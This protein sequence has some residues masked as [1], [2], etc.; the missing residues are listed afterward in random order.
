M[1]PAAETMFAPVE[2]LNAW[3]DSARPGDCVVYA[4]GPALDPSAAP[5][6]LVRRWIDGGEVL[7]KQQRHPAQAGVFHYIAQRRE[8]RGEAVVKRVRRNGHFEETPEGRLFL[9][10]VRLANLGLPCPCNREL[11]VHASLRDGEAVKYRLKLLE[12]SG[13]IEVRWL[14]GGRQVTI[15]ETGATTALVELMRTSIAR[16]IGA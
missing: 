14:S 4:T 10:L 7:A 16:R 6:A 2:R 9:V 5:A 3:M 8:Q 12:N 1:K 15:T 11:A 13:R